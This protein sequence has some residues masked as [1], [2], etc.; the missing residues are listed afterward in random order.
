MQ[1]LVTGVAGFLGY[2]TAKALLDDAIEVVGI[3][4]F[5]PY[6]DPA[7]KHARLDGLYPKHGFSF[8]EGDV[9]DAQLLYEISVHY[10][11]ITHVLHLAAQPGVRLSASQPELYRHTNIEGQRQ[12]LEFAR[13]LPKL[14]HV[15]YASSSAVYGDDCPLPFREDAACMPLSYYGETKLQGERMAAEY[16]DIPLTGLRLFTS[17]GPWGRPDMAYYSF[18]KSLYADEEITLFHHG[19]M[20]RDFT[21]VSDTVAGV[22]AALHHSANGQQ[23]FNIGNNQPHR[24]ADLLALLEQATGK[25]ARIVGSARQPIEPLITCA[26]ITQ[27]QQVLGYAPRI[28]LAEG[29]ERFVAWF[30]A[31]HG[32]S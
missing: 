29:I 31:H 22:I 3:D 25:T 7:L 26:D 32:V 9:A 13:R 23:V 21:Y 2:H 11:D 20:Q 17:Y 16:T 14:R 1:V 18:A 27:A 8:I 5:S 28:A 12:I 10:P 6:Y 19:E 4:N 24:V 30:S 15:V